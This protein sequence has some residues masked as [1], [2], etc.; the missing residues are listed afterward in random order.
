MNISIANFIF[1]GL[2][3][4][5]LVDFGK[6]GDVSD[7]TL[8]MVFVWLFIFCR[9]TKINRI[10]KDLHGVYMLG[11]AFN[12]A[13]LCFFF[14]YALSPVWKHAEFLNSIAIII[15]FVNLIFSMIKYLVCA[16]KSR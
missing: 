3:V 8:G 14:N 16:V 7:Y 13:A 4:W 15:L 2:A 9:N 5:F 12:L 6:G 1:K 11:L 10:R